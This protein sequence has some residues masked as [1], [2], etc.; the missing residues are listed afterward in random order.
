MSLVTVTPAETL[1]AAK[2][3]ISQISSVTTQ[4]AILHQVKMMMLRFKRMIANGRILSKQQLDNI[5]M[6]VIADFT[7]TVNI[8]KISVPELARY[9]HAVRQ[10]LAV[11]R[12]YN[13]RNL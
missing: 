10:H 7:N 5:I 2:S 12:S 11:T 13:E 3:I 9:N 4:L 6:E 1:R 8:F